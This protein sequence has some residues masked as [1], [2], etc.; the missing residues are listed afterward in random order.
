MV[1]KMEIWREMEAGRKIE[2]RGNGDR[3][4]KEC[5]VE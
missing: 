2:K 3:E 5:T 1:K 4:I